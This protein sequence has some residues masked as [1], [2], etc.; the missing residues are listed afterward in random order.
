MAA[1]RSR[2]GRTRGRRWLSALVLLAIVVVVAA[3]AVWLQQR[4]SAPPPPGPGPAPTTPPPQAQPA[5]CPDVQMVAVPGTWE[6]SPDDDPHHPEFNPNALLLGVTQPVQDKFGAGSGDDEG[7][8]VDVVTVP[9]VAQFARPFAPPETTYDASREAGT[10]ATRQ[11]LADRYSEC[12]LT[13]YVLIGFSQGAVIAGD[14]AAQIGHGNGPVPA[15]LVLGVGLVADGRRDA[16]APGAAT[17]QLGVPTG[18]GAEVMLGGL[19]DV[20]GF[21]GTTMTGARPDGFGVLADRTVQICAP[22]DLICDAPA[23][24]AGDL[25]GTLTKL[26]TAVSAPVHALYGSNPILPGG[27]TATQYL[28]GWAEDLIEGAPHPAHD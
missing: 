24:L 23:N 26:G 14:V 13:S 28:T 18:V 4:P 11:I 5:S 15:D 10:E 21:P 16:D 8:R 17:T 12:P 27:R 1:R 19:H 6:S 9:Y 22:G 20:P 25:I 2:R 3:V 7:G